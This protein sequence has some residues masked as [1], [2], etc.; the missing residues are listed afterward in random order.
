MTECKRTPETAWPLTLPL[1]APLRETVFQTARIQAVLGA[2]DKPPR[3][4]M[5]GTTIPGLGVRRAISWCCARKAGIAPG[6]E[7]RA[8][9]PVR[10]ELAANDRGFPTHAAS[11]NQ[12]KPRI[13]ARPAAIRDIQPIMLG[14]RR[15]RKDAGRAQRRQLGCDFL[16]LCAAGVFAIP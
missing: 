8:S 13:S 7:F 4:V 3:E 11:R 15:E 14:E 16:R 2:H 6:G 1:F 5:R 9:G 10:S 12:R